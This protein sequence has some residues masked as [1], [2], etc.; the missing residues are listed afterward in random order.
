MPQ[1]LKAPRAVSRPNQIK[2]TFS[3]DERVMLQQVMLAEGKTAAD[4]FRGWVV[5]A[6]L[7]GKNGRG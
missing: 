7:R 3:D 2:V 1:R 5:A 6:A 4:L